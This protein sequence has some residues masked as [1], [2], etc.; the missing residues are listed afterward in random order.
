MMD[1]DKDQYWLG[2]EQ[3]NKDPEFLKAAENEFMSSPLQEEGGESKVDRRDFMKLMGASIALT[4]AGCLERPVQKIIPYNKRPE[5]IV[6]GVANYY[7]S[8][9]FDG[10]QGTSIRVKTREGR[11]IFIGSHKD[12]NPLNGNGLTARVSAAVLDLYDPDRLRKP[13]RNLNNPE[14]TNR[15]TVG[16]SWDDLDAKVSEQLKKG[17]VRLLTGHLPSPSTMDLIGRFQRAF[18]ARHIVWSPNSVESLRDSQRESYGDSVVPNY[19]FD[20]AHYIV[21][22][23]CDFL[24]TYL[25]PAQFTHGFVQNRNPDGE[26]S[27]F[28]AFESMTTLTGMNADDRYRIKP[29]QQIDLVYALAHE[30]VTKHGTGGVSVSSATKSSLETYKAAI[31][32][33][34]FDA[35]VIEKTAAELWQ[36][37]G[38]SIVIT[39][40]PAI[41][42]GDAK[43]LHN[44]VNFL[45]SI[46]GNDGS[47]I[48]YDQTNFLGLNSSAKDLKNLIDDMEAGK[49]ETLIIDSS[50]NPG[51]N[52]P[53][54]AKFRAALS[55][56][57]M[58]VATSNYMDETGGLADY[59]AP[60]G[61]AMENWN[62]WEFQSGVYNLQQ[63]TIRPMFETR[64]MQDSLMAWLKKA[65]RGGSLPENFHDFIKSRYMGEIRS[66]RGN[67]EGSLPEDRWVSFLHNGYYMPTNKTE[68]KSR[69]RSFRTAALNFRNRPKVEGI[70]LVLFADS[71][72]GFGETAN[73]AWLQ[74]LPD[75]VTKI[76]WDNYVCVS[77]A[78]AKEHSIKDG[79]ML[80]VMMAEIKVEL[81]AHVLPGMHDDV[82]AIALG[83]GRKVRSLKVGY[84]IGFDARNLTVYTGSGSVIYSGVNVSFT[85]LNKTYALANTQGHHS[86]E[87]RQ[88]VVEAPLEGYKKDKNAGIHRHKFTEDIWTP[89]E[90][91]GHK[92]AMAVD[93]NSCV[94]CSACMVACQ[95]ENNIPIVGKKYIMRG[96]EMSWIR[97][98]RYWSGD[99]S[100]PDAVMQ[101]VMCQ[102]CENAPCER[103]CP[104][105]ATVHTDEGLNAMSYNRC[106]GTR[107]CSNNCP[108]KVRRFNWYNYIDQFNDKNDTTHMALNPD[109][110]VRSRG[111]MEK[112]TFCVQRIKEAK[113]TAKDENRLLK[114]GDIK[115]A[116]EDA[117][118]SGGIVFGD[119][120]DPDSRVSK[121]WKEQRAY[122]LLEEQQTKARVRYLAKVRNGEREMKGHHGDDHHG[123][124]NGKSN[125]HHETSDQG[126]AGEH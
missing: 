42:R 30:I 77:P 63:P 48:D 117:C 66:R 25:S 31:K 24:G 41:E 56:V 95:S 49:V 37:R 60:A 79:D 34:A 20:R 29:S 1:K 40:G 73:N 43:L 18:G 21:A 57:S 80:A 47:T 36:N 17:S 59:I 86:M 99:P 67:L 27:R 50:V 96:R 68:R 6:P 98:D 107:Y 91:T 100:S 35:S 82:M 106:V 22:I 92:W 12:G 33:M 88:I 102:H 2:L 54:S 103:V 14:R 115:V 7:A 15:E 87:G 124:M 3:L 108:Y 118:P 111:V 123:E 16:V 13:V 8:S 94:G 26:M 85:K 39:G 78:F 125:G 122:M 62:D 9:Y 19:R 119:I 75:P 23:D 121:L 112:C 53:D 126:K 72:V 71:K 32:D 38:K 51:L 45:N 83:Y 101:P 55:K 70:E 90:Y 5:E 28:V 89:F 11:P 104:V 65:G 109:V 120:A 44:A 61:H 116:C 110:T 84:D 52:L 58:T 81:P 46:L 10:I 64:S 4:S 74:E 113:N 69:G 105:L 76:V 97:I 93:L 114:D